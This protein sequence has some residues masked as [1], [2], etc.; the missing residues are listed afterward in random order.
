MMYAVTQIEYP[1]TIARIVSNDL[2][3]IVFLF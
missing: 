1:V 2:F 3:M